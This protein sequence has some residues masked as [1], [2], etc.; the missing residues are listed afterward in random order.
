MTEG[1]DVRRVV[2]R[3]E[4]L[5]GEEG[6]EFD[7]GAG[8]LGALPLDES[9]GERGVGLRQ[10]GFEDGQGVAM[11]LAGGVA[12]ENR[13]CAEEA[14]RVVEAEEAQGEGRDGGIGGEGAAFGEIEI[15]RRGVGEERRSRAGE[16][17]PSA[18]EIV[19]DGG[20]VVVPQNEDEDEAGEGEGYAHHRELFGAEEGQIFR[21]RGAGGEQEKEAG[22]GGG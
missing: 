1:G 10:D 11:G 20:D 22:A 9:A 13:E 6:G 17:E 5:A 18:A 21:A 3:V 7:V 8:G 15:G 4:T 19:G 12:E 2:G 16:I 14:G